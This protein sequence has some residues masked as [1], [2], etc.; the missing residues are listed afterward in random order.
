M[1][2]FPDN[3]AAPI[4]R[5][6]HC[7]GDLAFEAPSLPTLHYRCQ[8]PACAQIVALLPDPQL[9][10]HE[11]VPIGFLDGEPVLGYHDHEEHFTLHGSTSLPGTISLLFLTWQG[12][13]VNSDGTTLLQLPLMPDRVAEGDIS[14]EQYVWL[15]RAMEHRI[16][17]RLI[18]LAARYTGQPWPIPPNAHTP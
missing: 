15:K 5:C 4:T 18:A 1:E 17:D 16:L 12:E 8:N 13:T 2:S 3:P 14:L 9:D 7:G 11:V 6:P 10:L